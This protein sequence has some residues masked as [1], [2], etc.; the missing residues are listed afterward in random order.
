MTLALTQSATAVAVNIQASF[1]A[2][3]G[4][5]PYVYSVV[6]GGA[7][8]TIDADS[9]IYIAPASIPENP[10]QAFDTIQ[11]TDDDAATASA[12]ILVGSP[13]M[14]FC[15]ILQR[16][17]QLANGRV[18]VWDQKLFQPKDYGLY[19]AVSVPVC[20]PFGST[21][22]LVSTDAGLEQHQSVNMGATL[23]VD[24]I[25]RGPAARDRKEEV[26]LALNSVYAEQQQEANSFY[27][28]TLP[29][30]SRFVNLSEIDGAAI[31][32]RYRISLQMQ[33]AV[34]KIQAAQY[35]DTFAEP[36][37]I[38]DPP[39]PDEPDI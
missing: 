26:I 5:E 1:L 37:L 10:E 20:K 31:P 34:R 3:G 19:I 35:F 14:L 4:A 38:T 24:I 27:V 29:P 17:L 32:Y 30:S 21:C 13:L 33:Y 22:R 39:Q 18:Y 8:G 11:V 7:G 12:Q 6:A 25:S 28:G 2:T 9:G 36:T 23:D 15:E 16:E